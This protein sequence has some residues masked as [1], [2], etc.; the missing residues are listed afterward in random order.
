MSAHPTVRQACEDARSFARRASEE[1]LD[2]LDAL[3]GARARELL[4]T[5]AHALT[6]REA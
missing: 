1:A 2:A 5:L 4:R 3:P 6:R